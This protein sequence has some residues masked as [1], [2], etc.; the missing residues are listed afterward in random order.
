MKILIFGKGMLGVKFSK[1]FQDAILCNVDITDKDAV[2]SIISSEK[3]D[4]VI[5]AAGKTGRPNVDWCESHKRE[6]YEANVTGVLN[7]ASACETHGAYMLHMGSGCIFYGPSPQ[8]DGWSEEDFANPISFYSKT[9]YSAD[10]ILSQL[11]HVGI[12]RIRM[13]IDHVLDSRN[14]ICKLVGYPH[15]I[16]VENSVTFVEDLMDATEGLI[17]KK[18]QGIFH[19]VNPGTLRHRQLIESY[20]L[21][22][23]NYHTCHFI[24]EE[25]L[26]EMKLAKVQRS[27]VIL[28]SSRLQEIGINLRPVE[29]ALEDCMKKYAKNAI[30]YK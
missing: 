15:V 14:L 9:K 16:D 10:L 6:T 3:P 4:A 29:V 26:L 11:P 22:V 20:Q 24:K 19:V 21:Y 1:K 7:V 30:L 18:A 28:S 8:P 5:N 17:S 2:N 23:D 25:D 13:P 12:A 27:N